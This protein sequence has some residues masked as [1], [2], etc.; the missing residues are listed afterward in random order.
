MKIYTYRYLGIIDDFDSEKQLYSECKYFETPI[1]HEAQQELK[2]ALCYYD[3][4][5]NCIDVLKSIAN[6]TRSP[7]LIEGFFTDGGVYHNDEK[8][9]VYHC[10][11]PP[12]GKVYS[13]TTSCPI[14][15]SG[16]HRPNFDIKIL[17][18]INQRMKYF[19]KF[20]GK[21]RESSPEADTH[22]MLFWFFEQIYEG[23]ENL[24]WEGRVGH[25]PGLH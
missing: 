16:I 1:S 5:Q 6:V 9:E 22:T 2:Q 23:R 12:T 19:K 11:T 7:L 24:R 21:L 8:Y 15:V 13:S 14:A 4:L 3:N 20:M 10:F 17:E 25:H 18:L